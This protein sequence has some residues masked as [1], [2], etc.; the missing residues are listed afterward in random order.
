MTK[1]GKKPAYKVKVEHEL[2]MDEVVSLFMT[3]RSL[4]GPKAR[5]LSG[6]GIKDGDK[7][8]LM[9]RLSYDSKDKT[10]HNA[11]NL[12]LQLVDAIKNDPV[13]KAYMDAF[14]N[15]AKF[16][17]P[18]AKSAS[19]S[20][21][22]V[23]VF[24]MKDGMYF[25]V[26][27]YNVDGKDHAVTEISPLTDIRYMHKRTRDFGGFASVKGVVEV[28]QNYIE[29]M[30][31][32]I[33]YGELAN[34]LNLM[35]SLRTF[36]VQNLVDTINANF[37]SDMGAWLSNY[38]DDI[39]NMA[40]QKARGK[41]NFFGTLT[42]N[43]QTA[44]L[45]GN[46]GTPLKQHGTLWNSMSELDPRAVMKAA[47]T[48]LA[49]GNKII[50]N[51]KSNNI[52]LQYRGMGN[53]DPTIADA[54]NDERT[55]F[56]RLSA[57]SKLLQRVAGWIPKAD[58]AEVSKVYLASYYDVILKNPNVDKSSARFQ[59]LVDQ[60]FERALF[61]SQAQ[62]D[63][64]LR[65]AI[66]R[67][68]SNLLKG[69]TMFQTQQRTVANQLWEAMA[70]Q[71]ANPKSAE[72]KAKLQGTVT[73][74][75]ASNVA[76]G[77]MSLIGRLVRHKLYDLRDDDDDDKRL[78]LEKF[79]QQISFETIKAM[80]GTFI[81]GEDV[82]SVL[83]SVITKGEESYYASDVPVLETLASIGE[84]IVDLASS[85]GTAIQ[86]ADAIRKLGG[87]IANLF[88]IP[89]NNAYTS[90]NAML[91]W[92]C[93]I[94]NA[95]KR[96]EDKSIVGFFSELAKGS[97]I[98]DFT[99]EDRADFFKMS[100]DPVDD[101]LKTLAKLDKAVL[102]FAGTVSIDDGEGN[103][104]T[105]TLTNDERRQYAETAKETYDDAVSRLLSNGTYKLLDD[106]SKENVLKQAKEYSKGVAR[107]EIAQ[108]QG[109]DWDYEPYDDLQAQNNV[110]DYYVLNEAISEDNYSAVDY[111]L[112]NYTSI[113]KAV[114]DKAKGN[115]NLHYKDMLYASLLG[116]KSEEWDKTYEAVKAAT[117]KNDTDNAKAMATYNYLAGRGFSDDYIFTAIKTMVKPESGGET[118]AVVRRIEAYN[119]TIAEKKGTADL[120]SFLE[121][122]AL[123]TD[124]SQQTN[125][126]SAMSKEEMEYIWHSKGLSDYDTYAGLTFDEFYAVC[127]YSKSRATQEKYATQVD[128][129]YASIDPAEEKEYNPLIDILR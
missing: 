4:R 8:P 40:P 117:T 9:F 93:D 87:E 125:G 89:L 13:A 69:I 23:D 42:R 70:E 14:D 36:G 95:L 62:Y 19:T 15:A 1:D 98:R 75:V 41:D 63:M 33:A 112:K 35:R 71:R 49:P 99:T 108:G 97:S 82:A 127:K 88:G 120:G 110:L 68:D 96:N 53:V 16:I 55:I 113:S 129:V 59:R 102:G 51:A 2:S 128:E 123:T 31:N 91:M 85:D 109:Y 106:E 24:M 67:G 61:G 27:Y 43:F 105:L 115:T 76:Y 56:G 77:I 92:S 116:I 66:A 57:K 74:W 37:G 26:S 79:L 6:I 25:P 72:A 119:N 54:L 17:K 32:Y 78:T 60:T 73:G 30:S 7:A 46:I 84:G 10:V 58:V 34:K 52:L 122:I 12:E 94:V 38:I 5:R 22:G 11:N 101:I 44:V 86:N 50:K 103:K 20:I 111:L 29:S 81:F 21:S 65:D 107:E 64:N 18:Y 90:L 45:V 39:N 3:L 114:V 104:I 124:Y 80:A 48:S 121:L 100:D 47:I 118:A 83:L 126:D 28:T